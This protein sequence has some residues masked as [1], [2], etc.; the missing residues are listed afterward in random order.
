MTC[1]IFMRLHN[2]IL[3]SCQIFIIYKRTAL[4]VGMWRFIASNW[5]ACLPDTSSHKFQTL[6]H[7]YVHNNSSFHLTNL[8][9][10]SAGISRGVRPVF[11]SKCYLCHVRPYIRMCQHGCHWTYLRKIKCWGLRWESVEVFQIWLKSGKNIGHFV[12]MR[13]NLTL[14]IL[15]AIFTHKQVNY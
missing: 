14:F 15:L 5:P 8:P 11:K 10:G 6:E 4:G 13:K 2:R 12:R 3:Y 9:D 7:V 1:H